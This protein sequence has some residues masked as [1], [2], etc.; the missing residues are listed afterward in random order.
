MVV[1][2]GDE[3]LREERR[4][5]CEGCLR[6]ERIDLYLVREWGLGRR[7]VR[8]D[9]SRVGRERGHRSCGSGVEEDI[10]EVQRMGHGCL[11]FGLKT[12]VSGLG[13]QR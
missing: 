12:Q 7:S 6:S 2:P 4:C 13:V 10:C 5:R 1:C 8:G 9:V 3:C 11:S